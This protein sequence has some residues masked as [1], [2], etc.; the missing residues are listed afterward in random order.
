MFHLAM[1]FLSDEIQVITS[2]GDHKKA[3]RCYKESLKQ[4]NLDK[5][6]KMDYEPRTKTQSEVMLIELDC[7]EDIKKGVWEPRLELEASCQDLHIESMKEQVTSIGADL[8]EGTREILS[9]FMEA[10]KHARY[11]P[12]LFLS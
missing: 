5:S 3:C 11:S 9:S 8:G 12:K 6:N 2:K 10:N 7:R 1:K 4:N